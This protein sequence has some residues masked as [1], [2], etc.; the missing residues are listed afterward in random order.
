MDWQKYYE[1]ID[2][3]MGNNEVGR[4]VIDALLK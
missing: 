2:Y 3:V 1:R 4:A